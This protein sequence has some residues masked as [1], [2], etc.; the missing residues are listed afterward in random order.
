MSNLPT[1]PNC[2]YNASNASQSHI[3][4]SAIYYRMYMFMY[5]CTYIETLS[6]ISPTLGIPFKLI[7]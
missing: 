3:K 7:L 2:N 6:K 4:N 1:A 5:N